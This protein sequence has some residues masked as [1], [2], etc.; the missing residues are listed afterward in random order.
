[1]NNR[2]IIFGKVVEVNTIDSLEGK[3]LH[4][5]LSIYPNTKEPFD[6]QINYLEE[7][8]EKVVVNSNPSIHQLLENGIEFAMKPTVI[9]YTFNNGNIKHIDFAIKKSSR[10]RSLIIKC[11]NIQ[12]TSHHEAIGQWFHEYILV[13]LGF[14]FEK[15]AVV[16]SSAVQTK[17]GKSILF[18]GTGGVGKTSLEI[19]LCRNHQ[20]SFLADDISIVTYDGLVHPNLAYPKVYGYNIV[21]N[22][23]LKGEV[24][25]RTSLLNRLHFFVHS[26]RGSQYVRRRMSPVIFYGDAIREGV[27][28]DSYLILSKS[29][30]DQLI[31]EEIDVAKAV[32]LTQQVISREYGV[33]FDHIAW[34]EYNS[35]INDEKPTLTV[36]AM[37]E[38]NQSV[39]NSVFAKMKKIYLVKIPLTINHDVFKTEMMTKMKSRDLL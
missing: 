3:I 11:L 39:L 10:L 20:A 32:L 23:K 14:H 5:E 19:E 31:F 36:D 33:Y 1:M 21:G 15:L 30:V 29:N 37:L 25:K 12:F 4:D 27:P 9:R 38:K 16:H 13:P 2:Y 6:I 18:G 17:G 26:K 35:T 24:F 8:D 28:V 34:H 7:L 22:K